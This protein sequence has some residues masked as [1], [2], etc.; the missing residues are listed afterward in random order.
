MGRETG[1][2][3]TKQNKTPQ[4]NTNKKTQETEAM[5]LKPQQKPQTKKNKPR[6]ARKPLKND[7]LSSTDL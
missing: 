6:N 3:K 5:G 1:K 2:N 7:I 4:K